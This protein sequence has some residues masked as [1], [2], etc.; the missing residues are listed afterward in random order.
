[1]FDLDKQ[2]H[3]VHHS[4]TEKPAGLF[5]TAHCSLGPAAGRGAAI[6]VQSLFLCVCAFMEEGEDAEEEE[7]EEEA[8]VHFLL[9]AL[10]TARDGAFLQLV[11][12][13]AS[14]S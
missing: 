12:R 14:V 9:L 7:E 2:E 8:N 11:Q 10:N 4:C 3:L 1:M 6:A 13:A 5:G